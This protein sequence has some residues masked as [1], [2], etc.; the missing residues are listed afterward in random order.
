MECARYAGRGTRY[1]WVS[2]SDQSSVVCSTRCLQLIY[3]AVLDARWVLILSM[4]PASSLLRLIPI[5]FRLSTD[6]A[7]YVPIDTT[8]MAKSA[9]LSILIASPT[10]CQQGCAHLATLATFFTTVPVHLP[11]PRIP[12]VRL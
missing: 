8:L 3:R 6:L 11:L 9:P 12:T 10:K 1:G 7:S 4:V 5:V 2:A